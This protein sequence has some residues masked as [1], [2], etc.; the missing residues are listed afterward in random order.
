M[1][2]LQLCRYIYTSS[3]AVSIGERGVS[4]FQPKSCPSFVAFPQAEVL[5]PPGSVAVPPYLPPA[6]ESF[7]VLLSLFSLRVSFFSAPSHIVR[8]CAIFLCI[9]IRCILEHLCFYPYTC[10]MENSSVNAACSQAKV[11]GWQRQ[12]ASSVKS[13]RCRSCCNIF[14]SSAAKTPFGVCA[15]WTL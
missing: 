4:P 5:G 13:E 2:S 10:R 1:L 11:R 9:H 7:P 6:T 12:D 15:F 3:G 8:P 14:L